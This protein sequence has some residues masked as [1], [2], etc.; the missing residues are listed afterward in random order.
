VLGDR[1]EEVPRAMAA[2][3]IQHISPAPLPSVRVNLN[4][5]TRDGLVWVDGA[6][7]DRPIRTG[8]VVRIFEPVDEIEGYATVARVNDRTGLVYLDVAW[9][10]V[11][12]LEP[13]H[14]TRVDDV[15]AVPAAPPERTRRILLPGHIA[16]RHLVGAL[17]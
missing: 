10:S 6:D 8:W 13:I 1:G 7:F 15:E 2:F 9:E 3:V 17:Q 4:A 11:R 14:I 12:D 5:I 16:E